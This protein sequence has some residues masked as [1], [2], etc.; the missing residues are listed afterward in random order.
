MTVDAAYTQIYR[1][2]PDCGQHS[3]R[4]EAVRKDGFI[5]V[6]IVIIIWFEVVETAAV[7]WSVG[8]DN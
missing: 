8:N 2:A 7:T 6:P 5:P 1:K 4:G 3:V